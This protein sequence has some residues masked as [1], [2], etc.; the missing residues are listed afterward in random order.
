MV[1]GLV[2]VGFGSSGFGELCRMKFQYYVV[3]GA[4]KDL[5]E[6]TAKAFDKFA[7]VLK[8]YNVELVMWGHPFGTSANLMYILKA[9]IA[10]YQKLFGNSDYSDANPIGTGVLTHLVLVP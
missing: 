8:K 4:Q 6:G 7:A 2:L 1:L 5:P 3:Y 9:D 10:D